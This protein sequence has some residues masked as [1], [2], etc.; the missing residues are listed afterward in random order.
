MEA[1]SQLYALEALSLRRSFLY[2]LDKRMD[3][4]KA[5]KETTKRRRR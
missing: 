3:S 5:R 4:S 1:S 2:P